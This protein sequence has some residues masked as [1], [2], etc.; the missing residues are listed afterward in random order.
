[1]IDDKN[2]YTLF[3]LIQS[4]VICWN[5]FMPNNINKVLIKKDH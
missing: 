1:L 5:S 2:M 4:L 3:T